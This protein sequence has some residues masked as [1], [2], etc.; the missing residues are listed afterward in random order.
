MAADNPGWGYRRIHG[1]LAGLG[2]R[3]APSTVWLILRRAG[4]DPA[5]QR[6]GQSW[7]Q[8]LTAQ[9]EGILACDFTHVETVLLRRLYIFFVVEVATR[10]VWLLGVTA[11]PDGPWVTQC[12]RNLL[13]DLGDRAAPVPLPD[14]GPGQ[15]VHRRVRRRLHRRR[16]HDRA[17]TGPGSPGERD[18]RAVDRQPTPRAAGPDPDR[19][20]AAT[21]PRPRHLRRPLQHPSATPLPRT[22]TAGRPQ[23]SRHPPMTR[24]PPTT[25]ARR[26]DQRV[27][28]SA[29]R[30]ARTTLSAPTGLVA[31]GAGGIHGREHRRR[32]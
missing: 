25:A 4:I 17:H 2:H 8:F 5:P 9:A 23:H 24:R 20:P 7:R 19:Q 22:S 3:L 13:I 21:R 6:A 27:H 26:T 30:I 12:A 29:G 18:R 11:S 14:P 1:E 10:R 16:H 31:A 32:A 15:Q 28:V